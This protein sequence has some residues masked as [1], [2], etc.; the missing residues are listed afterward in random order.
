MSKMMSLSLLF[1]FSSF[2]LSLGDATQIGGG[3]SSVSE[4][5]DQFF[6]KQEMNGRKAP[7]WKSEAQSMISLVQSLK[8]I[9]PETQAKVNGW[10]RNITELLK[11]DRENLK[12]EQAAAKINLDRVTDDHVWNLGNLSQLLTKVKSMSGKSAAC[13]QNVSTLK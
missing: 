11:A 4:I 9:D 6:K 8:D 7:A 10:V 2:P 3:V 5:L 12:P 1:L 13:R